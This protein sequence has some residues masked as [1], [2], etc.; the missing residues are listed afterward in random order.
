MR[1]GKRFTPELLNKWEMEQ[2]RGRG[3]FGNYQPWHQNTRSD[4]AS[5]GR[6]HLVNC[7][8][9]SRLHHLLSDG[10]LLMFGFALMVPN[11]IDIREQ[12][13]LSLAS[14]YSALSEYSIYEEA[15]LNQGTIDICDELGIQHPK[16]GKGEKRDYWRLSTDFLLTLKNSNNQYS[17]IAAAYKSL[18]DLNSA[19]KRALL[20]IEQ[21]YWEAENVIWLLISPHQYSKAVAA[22]VKSVLWWVLGPHQSTKAEKEECAAIVKAHQ[23]KSLREVLL[24][25]TMQLECDLSH[26]NTIFYQTIWAGML[27]V[28]LSR[29]RLITDPVQLLSIEDFWRQNPIVS[30]RSVCL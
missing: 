27:P 3:T 18:E 13:M 1:K 8:L 15:F 10:E 24:A 12:F 17:L 9:T 21:K 23:G 19:R 29:S 28:D 5:R 4:P 30:R 25:I 14:H 2:A 11:L 22:T 16:V 7:S 20:R 26:T 6:A